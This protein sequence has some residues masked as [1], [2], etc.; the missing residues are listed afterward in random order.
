MWGLPAIWNNRVMMN[1]EMCYP[2]RHPEPNG[3]KAKR[4]AF[5]PR[6]SEPDDRKANLPAGRQGVLKASMKARRF[7]SR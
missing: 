3:R 2:S 6:H 7:F 1:E 5:L 4:M